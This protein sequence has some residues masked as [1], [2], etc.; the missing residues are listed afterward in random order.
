MFATY[1]PAILEYLS[2]HTIYHG[3]YKLPD[4]R[5]W[6]PLMYTLKLMLIGINAPDLQAALDR[7]SCLLLLSFPWNCDN[8]GYSISCLIC[9]RTPVPRTPKGNERQFKLV[10]FELLGSIEYSICH[11]YTCKKSVTILII[12]S[13]WFFSPHQCVQYVPQSAVQI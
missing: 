6:E 9:S 10:G 12:N 13:Y 3:S 5:K 1:I 8:L 2:S 4:G 7:T 11:V